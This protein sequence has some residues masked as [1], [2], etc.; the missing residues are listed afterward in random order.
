MNEQ[1]DIILFH[2]FPVAPY[3][4]IAAGEVSRKIKQSLK[5]IGIK[6]S[7]IRRIAIAAYEA[8]LNIVIHTLGGLITLEV[9]PQYVILVSKDTGPGIADI[10]MAMSEGYSTAPDEVREMGFGAGMGMSNMKRCADEFLIDSR[11]GG[12]TTIRMKFYL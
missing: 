10:D 1:K 4:F 2:S 12:E 3:D 8:E 6:D 5:K 9:T 7:I 11:T